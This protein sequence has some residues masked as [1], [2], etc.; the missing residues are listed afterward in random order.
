MGFESGSDDLKD[1]LSLL[2]ASKSADLY[3]LFCDKE[4]IEA[5]IADI[6]WSNINENRKSLLKELWLE[7][8]K[9]FESFYD[10]YWD[11]DEHLKNLTDFLASRWDTWKKY[12]EKG[13]TLYDLIVD[14][15][16]VLYEKLFR[17]IFDTVWKDEIKDVICWKNLKVDKVLSRISVM[18]NYFFEIRKDEIKNI[19]ER[20]IQDSPYFVR[21]M[22]NS[23]CTFED[24][25]NKFIDYYE[26]DTLNYIFK[27]LEQVKI[28]KDYDYV[29]LE[30]N[31]GNFVTSIDLSLLAKFTSTLVFKGFLGFCSGKADNIWDTEE[32]PE[33]RSVGYVY[34]KACWFFDGL[35]P[36]NKKEASLEWMDFRETTTDLLQK[37]LDVFGRILKNF[38]I[39]GN[40]V[41]LMSKASLIEKYEYVEQLFLKNK[42]KVFPQLKEYF[43]TEVSKPL[44]SWESLDFD[45]IISDL[46][47]KYG[48]AKPHIWDLSKKQR[49]EI[50]KTFLKNEKDKFRTKFFSAFS[51]Y[52]DFFNSLELKEFFMFIEFFMSL[53][54]DVQVSYMEKLNKD[55]KTFVREILE[56]KFKKSHNNAKPKKRVVP[57]VKKQDKCES[58]ER[59]KTP[60]NI[61]IEKKELPEWLVSDLEKYFWWKLNRKLARSLRSSFWEYKTSWYT[62]EKYWFDFDDEFF[63]ILRKYWFVCV[64]EEHVNEES[65]DSWDSQI[66]EQ[67]SW[68]ETIDV[69]DP[70]NEDMRKLMDILGS[71]DD[72]ETNEEKVDCYIKAFELFY[73]IK[74][75]DYIKTQILDWID[76]DDRISKWIESIFYKILNG[77]RELIRKMDRSRKRYYRFDVGYNTWYRVVFNGQKWK[78]RKII[79]DFVDHDTYEDR[80]PWYYSRY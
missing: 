68:I 37:S 46:R 4:K 47:K 59:K 1:F 21:L 44:F 32:I 45:D 54:G 43:F 72:L 26:T 76:H 79:I 57:V 11:Y 39:R 15:D 65:I 29:D 2:D 69:V 74:D 23:N 40:W 61:V 66:T 80:I 64:D 71:L 56:E 41:F 77:Y 14:A 34:W 70:N 18:V 6:E 36:G 19:L 55:Y 8:E 62:K 73:D 49:D 25:I 31:F 33:Y 78:S 50:E 52:S 27:E 13:I 28:S 24:Y 9:L 58:V 51:Q 5:D 3:S 30:D 75:K 48:H 60:T 22:D 17:T 12:G 63:R 53:L 35:F 7:R 38:K 10:Y 42:W 67:D 20:C 16:K